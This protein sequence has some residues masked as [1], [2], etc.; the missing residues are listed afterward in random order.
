MA[1]FSS[2]TFY[3]FYYHQYPFFKP[4]VPCC[5]WR[6]CLS[7]LQKN[8]LHNLL[9]NSLT[10]CGCTGCNIFSK[11]DFLGKKNP[12]LLTTLRGPQK[13]VYRQIWRRFLTTQHPLSPAT[14][15]VGLEKNRI[16]KF[17]AP[18]TR[19][20]F[21][22]A[23]SCFS[24]FI[25]RQ[26]QHCHQSQFFIFCW[27]KFP[28]NRPIYAFALNIITHSCKRAKQKGVYLLF[29]SEVLLSSSMYAGLLNM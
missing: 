1:A 6:C 5:C 24:S 25:S 8:G 9:L 11:L 29:L 21:Y 14:S 22:G 7:P 2:C 13:H 17:I 15:I 4:C 23:S 10:L 18:G 16:E 20:G 19:K 12:S 3:S 27:Y 26:T 28:L